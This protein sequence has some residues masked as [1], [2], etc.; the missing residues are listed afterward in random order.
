MAD[1]NDSLQSRNHFVS[2]LTDGTQRFLAH[3]MEHALANGRRTPQDFIR[4]F[5]PSAI[6]EGLKSQSRLRAQILVLAT[7]VKERIAIKKTASSAADDLQIALDE[8]ETDAETV[9]ALFDPDDRVRY[10]DAQRL[11]SFLIEGDFW[12]VTVSKKEEFERA[13]EHVAF[14]LDRA[15]TDK[16]VTHRDVVE[17]ITVGEI[18]TRLP[19][20]E[21]HHIIQGALLQSH[22]NAPFTEGDLLGTMPTSTLLKYVP[23]PHL[24]SSVI[25]PKV[26]ETHGFTPAR[27]AA[28]EAAT[29]APAPAR[30]SESD[31]LAALA[32][33]ATEP[34]VAELTAFE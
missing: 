27:A 29:P 6:M 17:G 4:H 24:W 18:V 12:N 9:V 26:A 22:K 34:E 13:K 15:L 14:V 23:L 16:L 3:V 32:P 2:K 25:G 30:A 8:G 20:A 21:L 33:V 19:K 31:P 5:P 28:S 10:L 1:G 11:W 7:G